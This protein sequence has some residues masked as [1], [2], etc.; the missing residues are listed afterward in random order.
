MVSFL[1]Q[2]SHWS[3]AMCE[4]NAA[5]IKSKLLKTIEY[6]VSDNEIKDAYWL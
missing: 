5:S 1:K 4:N 6:F 2:P 3:R